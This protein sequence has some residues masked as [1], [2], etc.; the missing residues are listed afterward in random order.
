MAHRAPKFLDCILI[1][2]Y[3]SIL[4]KNVCLTRTV[5][6]FQMFC[7]HFVKFSSRVLL[8]NPLVSASVHP[9][10]TLQHTPLLQAG[11]SL[12]PV[13][14]RHAFE[15]WTCKITQLLSGGR[16]CLTCYFFCALNIPCVPSS[17]NRCRMFFFSFLLT[18]HGEFFTNAERH[19]LSGTEPLQG[20]AL[21]FVCVL[22]Y[23]ALY[24]P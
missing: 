6:Q 18:K 3:Y 21:V 19:V 2:S 24:G 15:C 4:Q 10:S 23:M 8:H 1:C 16:C 7:P 11:S 22:V 9:P 17:C 14:W 12:L 13:K 20:S 5:F